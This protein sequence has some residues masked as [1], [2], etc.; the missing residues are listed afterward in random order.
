MTKILFLCVWYCSIYP[1]AFFMCSFSLFVKYFTD[2]FSLMRSWKRAPQL[3]TR[4]SKFSRRYFFSLACVAMVVISSFYWSGF[5]FDNICPDENISYTG[6]FTVIQEL[7]EDEEVKKENVTFTNE[8]LDYRFCSQ[9]LIRTGLGSGLNTFPFVPS[10][11]PVGDEW[12]NEDQEMV[13]LIFGWTSVV[14]TVLVFLKF[15]WGWVD[16]YKDLFYSSYKVGLPS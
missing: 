13:T 5:P 6:N 2:R 1:G 3:G 7:D 4:V 8:D 14:I 11:Q 15:V 9:D 16:A 10:N 12:M